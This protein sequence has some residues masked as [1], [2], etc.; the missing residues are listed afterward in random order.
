MFH[1]KS[2]W[3]KTQFGEYVFCKA[4]DTCIFGT[5]EA[6]GS[7]VPNLPIFCSSRIPSDW[8]KLTHQ[9]DLDKVERF[10][11]PFFSVP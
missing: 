4:Q 3:K 2:P 7:L 11:R 1:R 10:K 8:Q 6:F 5:T 9:L